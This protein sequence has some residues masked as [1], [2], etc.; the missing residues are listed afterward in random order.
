M[1]KF[2]I[3]IHFIRQITHQKISILS[4]CFEKNFVLRNYF[5]SHVSTFGINFFFGLKKKAYL[6]NNY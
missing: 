1:S 4:T 5:V 3:L 6:N 2:Y